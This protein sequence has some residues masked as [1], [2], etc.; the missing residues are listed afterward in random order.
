MWIELSDSLPEAFPQPDLLT[1]SVL[2]AVADASFHGRHVLY[3]SN[4]TLS[5][6]LK[7]DLSGPAKAAVRR[8]RSNSAVK[9]SVRQSVRTKLIIEASGSQ[10]FRDDQGNWHAPIQ[11]MT[12][13]PMLRAEVLAEN[14]RDVAALKYAALHYRK[15]NDF[16]AF[17]VALMSHNGGGSEILNCFQ[18]T[19]SAREKFTCAVTDS[20]RDHP[21]AGP[22]H[23]SRECAAESAAAT[24]ICMH[25][26]LPS[27]EM[28]N[29]LPFN[30][31]YDSIMASNENASLFEPLGEI[32]SAAAKRP[33]ILKYMDMKQ[34]TSGSIAS[35]RES[36]LERRSFWSKVVNECDVEDRVCGDEC[37]SHPCDCRIVPGIGPLVLQ[38]F[39]DYCDIISI[40]KQIERMK[41]SAHWDDWLQVGAQVFDW[42]QA[43]QP[44]RA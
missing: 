9:G 19:L 15:T 18:E 44:L 37:A 34:G 26:D 10:V 12:G 29:L 20:D 33:D 17:E 3:G 32:A 6:L 40:P 7:Q 30:L 41:T 21:T 11:R 2:Q 14:T 8:A 22:G 27:R 5:W 43:D 36:N 16:S 13:V 25:F 31:V 38:R 28:E 1:C 42:A 24:W 35:P 4:G 39:L 23:I